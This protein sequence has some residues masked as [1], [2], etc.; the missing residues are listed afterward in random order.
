VTSFKI[1]AT[2]QSRVAIGS[3]GVRRVVFSIVND[4]DRTIMARAELLPSEAVAK[5]WLSIEGEKERTFRAAGTQ[6]F[7]VQVTPPEDAPPGPYTFR[8]R[9]LATSESSDELG[10][11]SEPIA[12]EVA[13]RP[14]DPGP[15]VDPGPTPPPP[16]DWRRIIVVG[17]VALAVILLL[18]VLVFGCGDQNR[19]PGPTVSAS[20]HVTS[21]AGATPT[22]APTAT[23]PPPTVILTPEPTPEVCAPR[24]QAGLLVFDCLPGGGMATQVITSSPGVG[25]VP[26]PGVA[27]FFW[28][29]QKQDNCAVNGGL[30]I[31]APGD[32]GT[33]LSFPA[34]A[35]AL[36]TDPRQCNDYGVEIRFTNATT[37]MTIEVPRA[38]EEYGATVWDQTVQ[39][40]IG[41]FQGGATAGTDGL[42]A[43]RFQSSQPFFDVFLSRLPDGEPLYIRS[44]RYTQ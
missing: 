42:V 30:A 22:V 15:V 18:G 25:Y 24:S 38:D 19:S 6:T 16:R 20:P 40:Q 29:E 39:T 35:P 44:I 31:L 13:Q 28:P 33:Y 4:T 12:F 17:L 21:S 41:I 37:G 43:F 7:K 2:P 3:D 9:V 1:S 14:V 5:E 8:I 36:L 32:P 34:L 26:V 23:P 10:A 11:V 27:I